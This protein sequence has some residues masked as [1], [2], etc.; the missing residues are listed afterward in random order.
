MLIVVT[1][2]VLSGVYISLLLIS[3]DML[4]PYNK[5]KEDID[6]L[7]TDDFFWLHENGVDFVFLIMILHF[8]IRIY[9]MPFTKEQET[10]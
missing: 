3:D 1:I 6:D 10:T 2:Q 4:I 5:D 7:Y 8:L 9:Q